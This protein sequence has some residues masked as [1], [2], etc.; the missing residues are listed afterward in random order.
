[1]REVAADEATRP[2]GVWWASKGGKSS[3]QQEGTTRSRVGIV[4]LDSEPAQPPRVDNA[5]LCLTTLCQGGWS[6]EVSFF[7][8][9][10]FLAPHPNNIQPPFKMG[11]THICTMPYT[12]LLTKKTRKEKT[13]AGE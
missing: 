3:A 4:P 13:T 12:I 7:V 2:R 8:I 11:A 9:A 5:P 6:G 1:M 10:T